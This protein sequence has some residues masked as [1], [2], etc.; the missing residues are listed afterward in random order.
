MMDGY[1]FW[2]SKSQSP[3]T[4]IIRLGRAKMCFFLYIYIYI[5]IYNSD[6]ICLKEE[7]HIHGCLRVSKSC[8]NFH[9]WV[10]FHFESVHIYLLIQTRHFFHWRKLL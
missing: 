8:G 4:A 10:N 2:A 6:C 1:T 5:Y 7:S 9:F 3:F